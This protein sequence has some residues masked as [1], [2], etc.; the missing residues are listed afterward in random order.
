MYNVGDLLQDIE[1]G[2]LALVLEIRHSDLYAA[3]VSYKLLFES[4][5]TIW[6]ASGI[7]YYYFD[8]VSNL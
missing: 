3:P 4:G 7:I 8:R 1:D 5:V 2:S 6:L